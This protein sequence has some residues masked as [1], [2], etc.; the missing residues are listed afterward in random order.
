[1]IGPIHFDHVVAEHRHHF[2][3]PCTLGAVDLHPDMTGIGKPDDLIP[4]Y[5]VATSGHFVIKM[6]YFF[7]DCMNR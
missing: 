5:R 3:G 1:M 6:T 7:V 2:L 4:G